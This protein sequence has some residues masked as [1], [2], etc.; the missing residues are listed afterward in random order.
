MSCSKLLILTLLIF[1]T[2]LILIIC[3]FCTTERSNRAE[4][5]LDLSD[6]RFFCTKLVLTILTFCTQ[7]VLG[8]VDFLYE[9]RSYYMHV[10]YYRKESSR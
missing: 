3:M 1:C 5:L 2:E 6:Y 9:T 8:I 7:L 4:A 10:L